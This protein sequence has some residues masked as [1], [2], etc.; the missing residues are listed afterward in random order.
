MTIRR[1]MK[2]DLPTLLLLSLTVGAALATGCG[3]DDDTGAYGGGAASGYAGKVNGSAGK[4]A[5]AGANS[6]GNAGAVDSAG[7]PAAGESAG[8]AAGGAALPGFAVAQT[9]LD[10]DV[11]GM[12]AQT[13]PHLLNAWAIAINPTAEVFW[14]SSNHGGSTPVYGADGAIKPVD[15]TVAPVT[16]TDPGSPTG[17]VFN[18]GTNFKADKFIVDT[19]DGQILGWA[20][21]AAFTQRA[22]SD[23]AIYKGLALVGT[24]ATQQLLAANFHDGSVD[25]FDVNYAVVAEP[26]AFK[27]PSVPAGYAPF[28]VVPIGDQVFVAYA[29]QDTDK[30][31]DEPGTGNGYVSVFDGAG[32]LVK[33]WLS[34]GKLDSPWAISP[35]PAGFGVPTTALLVGNFGSGEIGAY[36]KASGDFLGWLTDDAGATLVIPGLW[37]LKVGPTGTTDL[38]GSLFFTAGPGGEAH[39]LFGKLDSAATK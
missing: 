20:A 31:D 13:D 21:G 33:S 2:T 32:K 25:V 17:Q 6:G 27:D 11:T 36:D 35:A 18:A 8:G 15:P 24:G 16:G 14:I 12:A 10:S 26:T 28:N 7:A 37:D 29:K 23:T 39:G 3:S 5:E 4:S 19:E 9:N 1:T 38:S 30:A 22:K 34:G